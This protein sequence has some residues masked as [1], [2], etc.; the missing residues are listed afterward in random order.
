MTLRERLL[1]TT[2]RLN[3]TLTSLTDARLSELASAIIADH[4]ALTELK[5]QQQTI[6]EIDMLD[7]ID[8]H[9]AG[10]VRRN[11]TTGANEVAKAVQQAAKRKRERA[12]H[13]RKQ[14]ETEA[15]KVFVHD[16]GAIASMLRVG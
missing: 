1:L 11:T 15:V 2:P 6:E 5:R 13:E 7:A 9:A 10:V 4:N 14:R 12:D 3:T 16:L 8:C